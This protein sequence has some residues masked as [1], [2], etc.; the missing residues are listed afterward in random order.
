MRSANEFAKNLAL[1]D[2][3]VAY[4]DERDLLAE[5]SIVSFGYQSRAEAIASLDKC[6]RTGHGLTANLAAASVDMADR[7]LDHRGW[8]LLFDKFVVLAIGT[9]IWC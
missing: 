6:G 7:L 3:V 9:V 5:P 8:P 4:W 1:N 2:S